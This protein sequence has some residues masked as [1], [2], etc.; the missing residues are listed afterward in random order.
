MRYAF[1]VNPISG[2]GKK[3]KEVIAAAEN[4]IRD[5][6]DEDI[7]ICPTNAYE[8]GAK[9]ADTLAS[10]ALK[11]GDDVVV[12]ACGGDGTAHEIANG[13]YGYDNAILGTVP[14]GTGNDLC[15]ALAKDKVHFTEYLNLEKQLNGRAKEIDVIEISWMFG[16][17]EK[18]CIC[19]NGV[20]IGFDGNT[21][22][23]ATHIHEKT[24]FKGSLAYL[25]AV[26]VT[27]VGKDG[28][29]LR[30][31]A[32]GEPFYD[33]DLLLATMSNG[34]YCG[35]GIESC[36]NAVLD[37]GLIELLAIKDMSRM[38]FISKFPKFKA[39]RLFD[40][41]DVDDIAT[42]KQV[43]RITVEPLRGET[44]E[45]VIDGEVYNTPKIEVEIKPRALK[46]WEI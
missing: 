40:I 45:F 2:T 37:D 36:P 29:S 32:D 34:N 35:G 31:T 25:A 9:I 8:N 23:R 10:E 1:I 14:I 27:L 33:G 42:Y 22:V 18:S 16:S 26:F 17:T 20:N 12:F 43:K 44:M 13:I 3:N 24:M 38:S 11:A 39:G 28:Q 21:A 4:L 19:V 15:R 5:H 6:M 7:I 41:K 30:I 46:L